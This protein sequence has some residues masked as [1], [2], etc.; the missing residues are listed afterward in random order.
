VSRKRILFTGSAP[1]HFACA[2]PVYRRL[3][4]D[5]R[6]EFWLSGGFKSGPPEAPVY[7]LPGFYEPFGVDLSRVIPVERS[8]QEDFDVVVAAHLNPVLPR[9]HGKTVQ[10]FHGVSFKNLLVREKYT[11][12]DFLCLA[13]RYHAEV[14]RRKGYVRANAGACLVTGFAKADRLVDGSLDRTAT[15][16][17]IGV[18]PRLPTILYAP[19]GSKHNSMETMGLDVIR[20]IRDAGRWNLVVKLHDHP[21]LTD[22][23]WAREVAPL[24]G[25]RVRLARDWDIVPALHAADLVLTDASSAAVEF[26]LLD[27]P[28]VFIDVP[29]LFKDVMERGGALD[30]E[31]HGRSVGSVVTSVGEVVG[32][33]EDAF[34]HPAREGARRRAMAAHVF[35]EPGRATDRTT[36]VVLHAAGLL[37]ALPPDIEKL[38]PEAAPCPP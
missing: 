31:T 6:V 20:R 27:R 22:V 37:D 36:S 11:V 21:K 14:Y 34:A 25:E 32:A 10:V 38:Q 28:I 30:L 35:H 7:S 16:R 19:T 13:G 18:D 3:A 33:I 23:D 8:R 17:A 29:E 4:A 24:E 9:A 2:L 12:F 26:T 1:V 15:L 5:P